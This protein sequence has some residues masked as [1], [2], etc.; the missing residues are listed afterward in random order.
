M[1]K[2]EILRLVV[3]V[4]LFYSPTP[5]T[6]VLYL[7]Y[8]WSQLQSMIWLFIC[9]VS[10]DFKTN[11]IIQKAAR[12]SP[13]EWKKKKKEASLSVG[14]GGYRRCDAAAWENISPGVILLKPYFIVTEKSWKT[15]GERRPPPRPWNYIWANKRPLSYEGSLQLNCL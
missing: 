8:I 4:Y 9:Y 3:T 15:A 6:T 12:R 1:L 5:P 13:E 11:L 7:N 2:K 14:E 10:I